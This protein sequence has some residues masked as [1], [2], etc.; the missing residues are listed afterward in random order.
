M[1]MIA[2]HTY[3]YKTAYEHRK[4]VI[5]NFMILHVHFSVKE[6]FY[7]CAYINILC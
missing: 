4:K 7:L 3:I 6:Y 2:F 1:L 5:R